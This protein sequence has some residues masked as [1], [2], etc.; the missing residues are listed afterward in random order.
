M[1]IWKTLAVAAPFAAFLL[2]AGPASSAPRFVQDDKDKKDE[3]EG[4]EAKEEEEDRWFALHNADVHTGTGAVLRGASILA[5][6]GVIEEIGYDLF[7]PDDAEVL[8]AMGM[9]AYPGL[10]ALN[11]TTSITQPRSFGDVEPPTDDG[12]VDPEI[13]MDPHFGLDRTAQQRVEKL[14]GHV[15]DEHEG[16][17]D[18]P[19]PDRYTANEGLQAAEVRAALE[20][21]FDPFSQNLLLALSTGITTADQSGAAMKLRR[22]EIDDVLMNEKNQATY[23]W[24]VGNPSSIRSVREKFSVAAEYQRAFEEWDA[25]SS[26]KKKETK[27]PKKPKG[28]D[29][30]TYQVLRG[31]LL[32]RFNANDREDLLG[33]ARFA[34]EFHFR[35]VLWG[36]REG[37][38]V[39]GELGRA[40]AYA[41]ITPRDRSPKDERLLRPGGTSIENAAIL[42]SHGVQIAIRPANASFSLGGITG[43]DLLHLPVEAAFGVRGGLSSTLR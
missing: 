41:V 34:Q 31:E 7:V 21:S 17:D 26:A 36:C 25:L 37:W 38:T 35:P 13:E 43:R 40:G 9:R 3:A 19:T 5:K 11:A 22:G 27:E 30:A 2:A 24:S 6:N 42:S 28:F 10:V 12:H 8:D 33:I 14:Y 39:A 29:A 15:G 18:V 4:K 20:D 1:K 32:A 23:S 16:P